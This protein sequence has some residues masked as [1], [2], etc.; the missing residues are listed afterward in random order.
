MIMKHEDYLLKAFE[1]AFDGVRNNYGGPFGAVVVRDGL[2]LG[3]GCNR[4][5]ST[6]DPTA[7]AEVM[8]IRN[9]CAATSAFHLEGAV[10]YTTCEP[11]PMCLSAIYWAKISQ[12]YYCSSRNDAE[13][14]GFADNHIYRELGINPAHTSLKISRILLPAGDELFREWRNKEDRTDY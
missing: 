11:C 13:S 8:A 14:I 3:S 5:T 12:V 9:A 10:I 4:V 6:H 2:I 7:H 1:C